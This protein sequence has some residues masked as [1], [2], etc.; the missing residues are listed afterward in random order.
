MEFKRS[1]SEDID[2]NLL[3]VVVAFSN[4]EGGILIIGV[5]DTNREIVGCELDPE[6]LENYLL[7]RIEPSI[8]GLFVI[9]T[10]EVPDG[11]H[12]L[13]VEVER[14]PQLHALKIEGTAKKGGK[15]RYEYFYRSAMSSRLMS[16]SVLNRVSAI[17]SDLKYNFNFRIRIFLDI[18]ELLSSLLY[19]INFRGKNKIDEAKLAELSMDYL[20][21]YRE[22][23]AIDL[24]IVKVIRSMRLE[25]LYQE[26]WESITRFYVKILEAEQ[27]IPHK[28]LT[29][30]EDMSLLM[31]KRILNH[32]LNID[33][34]RANVEYLSALKYIGLDH[35]V[36]YDK[37]LYVFSAKALFAYMLDYLTP[38]GYENE[39]ARMKLRKFDIF[40][41]NRKNFNFM[42]LQ[43]VPEWL[44]IDDLEKLM[45]EF[46]EIEPDH[47][48]LGV[49]K[50][51]DLR[52]G[53]FL[54]YFTLSLTKMI[55]KL[56]ELRN[57]LYLNLSIPIK[58][59]ASEGEYDEYLNDSAVSFIYPA[60]KKL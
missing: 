54:Y 43:P 4:S 28:E 60:H 30:E 38:Q 42:L 45:K 48:D 27:Y 56:I 41:I 32:G 2:K 17:K 5:T 53:Q 15:T 57:H 34:K 19:R 35:E 20:K 51:A 16:P 14:S 52:R 18:N 58:R 23:N 40:L 39:E 33:E 6:T 25:F 47:T 10:V 36:F 1:V 26:I 3:R 46:L 13:I 49:F 12:V 59:N 7:S 24:E 9:E 8:S 29:F 31:L 44:T 21:F 11:K 37:Q 22:P 55:L 50:K